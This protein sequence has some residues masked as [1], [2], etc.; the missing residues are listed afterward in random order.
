MSVH[1]HN[2]HVTH[3]LDPNDLI[4]GYETLGQTQLTTEK[5]LA[6]TRANIVSYKQNELNMTMRVGWHDNK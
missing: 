6:Q 1:Y 4:P 2:L 3:K 5:E